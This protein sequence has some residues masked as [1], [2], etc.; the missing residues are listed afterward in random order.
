MRLLEHL[1]LMQLR[2]K[3]RKRK[4][5]QIPVMI[6]PLSHIHADHAVNVDP[7][8]RGQLPCYSWER[9]SL[10]LVLDSVDVGPARLVMRAFKVMAGHTCFAQLAALSP[11]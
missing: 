5:L 8:Q 11:P 4:Y 3:S 9:S 2:E 10:D 7:R 6:G 1:T